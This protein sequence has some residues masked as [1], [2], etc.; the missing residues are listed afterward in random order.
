MALHINNIEDKKGFRNYDFL[1]QTAQLLYSKEEKF[2]HGLSDNTHSID[3]LLSRS[4]YPIQVIERNTFE[5][6]YI[7]SKAERVDLRD[8][9]LKL[10]IPSDSIFYH[11]F[12]ETIPQ[13][14]SFNKKFPD[15]LIVIDSYRVVSRKGGQPYLDFLKKCL[16]NNNIKYLFL[17]NECVVA[18]NNFYFFEGLDGSDGKINII[19]NTV[20]Q[21]VKSINTNPTKKVYISRRYIS[22]KRNKYHLNEM[23]ERNKWIEQDEIDFIITDFDIRM[24]NEEILE[25]FF[26]S[27][28]F[29][30]VY[31]ENF[32]SFEEQINYFNDVKTVVSTTS[33]GLVNTIFMP[34]GGEVIELLTPNISGSEIGFELYCFQ[35]LAISYAKKH[36]YLGIP[37]KFDGSLMVEYL[38]N[39]KQLFNFLCDGNNVHR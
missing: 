1:D 4:F 28:N 19:Y 27:C 21:F 24:H 8:N 23:L 30:I 9:R 3:S 31:P 10:F 20:K 11:F 26:K 39:N 25:N 22:G 29:E 36:S 16:D 34:P 2:I 18:I 5:S 12:L 6:K 15:A 17:E 7:F 33:S 14:M 32:N 35:Y 13:I 37:S 38:Y